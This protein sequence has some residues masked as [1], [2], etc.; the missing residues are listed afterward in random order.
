[1]VVVTVTVSIA[2]VP[3]PVP[4]PVPIPIPI[5][6]SIAAVTRLDFLPLLRAFGFCG[7]LHFGDAATK[8]P[9]CDFSEW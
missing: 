6:V 5:T 8:R 3:V 4:I 2:A 9:K 1:V 7:G